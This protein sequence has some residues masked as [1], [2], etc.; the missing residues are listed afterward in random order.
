M[1]RFYSYLNFNGTTE[2]AFNFYKSVFGG[3]FSE[4]HRFSET[5]DAQNLSEDIR[6]KLMHISLPLPGGSI[7]MATDAL[8]AMGQHLVVGNNVSISID[9]DSL[10]QAQE[11]FGKLSVGGK[12]EMPFEKAFWG[13]FFGSLV[14]R[15]GIQW[16]INFDEG[17]SK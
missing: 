12:I 8:E 17:L 16:M 2:E 5:P 11:Y 14:D 1:P 3:E 9:A 6:N 4:V 13:A 7:L 15:F 10:A